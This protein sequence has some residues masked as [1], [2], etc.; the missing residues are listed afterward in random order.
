MKSVS[1]ASYMMIQPYLAHIR[2]LI[3]TDLPGEEAHK[4]MSPLDRPLS[5]LALKEA[6]DYKESA[7][8]VILFD[9]GQKAEIVL[10]QRPTY[11]G[12]HSGQIAFPGGKKEVHDSDLKQTSIRECKEEIG[13]D[14]S[15]ELYLGQLTPV[16]I[17]VSN[18]YVEPH[19]FYYQTEE[20][21]FQMDS[22]EVEE[23]FTIEMVDLLN[24]DNQT[25]ERITIMNEFKKDVPCFK[26]KNKMIWGATA[27]ML[28][29][30][31][32]IFLKLP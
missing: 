5:S 20:L 22:F 28:N 31:K 8:S 14:L 19:V 16:Y 29:E 7:V 3:Q 2:A 32:E 18:F 25:T 23:I 30:L 12:K 4:I 15:S 13:I 21:N 1:L 10:I 24:P 17:P 27:L 9:K 26:I 6:S 11:D